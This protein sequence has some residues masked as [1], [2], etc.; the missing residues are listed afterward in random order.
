MPQPKKNKFA[1]RHN[2]HCIVL[3]INGKK[4]LI[5][6]NTDQGLR[7]EVAKSVPR[8]GVARRLEDKEFIW[9]TSFGS[10]GK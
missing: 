7:E 1:S 8:H 3:E 5:E 10:L 6:S 9:L 4:T 2:G